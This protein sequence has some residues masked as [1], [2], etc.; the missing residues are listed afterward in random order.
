ME[1]NSEV[2]LEYS[3]NNFL[4]RFGGNLYNVYQNYS[5][6]PSSQGKVFQFI[7]CFS[8]VLLP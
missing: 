5:L 1:N 8:V 6:T 7:G 3:T 2:F 4:E